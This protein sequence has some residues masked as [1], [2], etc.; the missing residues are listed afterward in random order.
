MGNLS[1]DE[2]KGVVEFLLASL[3]NGKIPHGMFQKAAE[4]FSCTRWTIKRIWDRYN[5]SKEAGKV[6]G[7]VDSQIKA[8][9]GRKGYDTIELMERI[10]TV[11]YHK[12]R[13]IARLAKALKV[14][15]CVLQRL[16]KKGILRKHSNKIKP[17]ITEENKLQ[18]VK[19]ASSWIDEKTLL[20]DPM[21]NVVHI[22]EKWF[23]EDVDTKTYYLLPD[24]YSEKTLKQ[25][26][27][28][29]YRRKQ[30]SACQICVFLD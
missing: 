1:N 20:F 22:D 29:N 30:A 17:L 18:R 13:K 24:R 9:S 27:A 8:R 6:Y 16:R 7:N 10:R 25:N 26:Q 12:R 4:K 11:P 5:A 21:F 28:S 3:V 19:F 14:S 23:Y 2:R 15:T